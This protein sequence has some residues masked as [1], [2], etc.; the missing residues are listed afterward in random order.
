[1]YT[2]FVGKS[3]IEE[4]KGKLISNIH[5]CFFVVVVGGGYC[6]IT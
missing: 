2:K 4:R 3:S 5:Y 1:M 6:F